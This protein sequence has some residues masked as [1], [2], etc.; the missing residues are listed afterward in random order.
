MPHH[1]NWQK[2]IE[3]LVTVCATNERKIEDSVF[4]YA[5]QSV[6]VEKNF[7]SWPRIYKMYRIIVVVSLSVELVTDVEG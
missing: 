3:I 1:E 7:F 5:N 6:K 4:F 2:I